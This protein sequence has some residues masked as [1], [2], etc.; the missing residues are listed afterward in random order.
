MDTTTVTHPALNKADQ[1]VQAAT[2][3]AQSWSQV[4]G[5]LADNPDIAAN[6]GSDQSTQRMHVF[7]GHKPD[8]VTVIADAARRAVAAGA[9]PVEHSHHTF[10]GVCLRFGRVEVYV[11]ARSEQVCQPV[12]VGMVPDVRH[13][14]SIALDE[15]TVPAGQAG[16]RPPA[17]GETR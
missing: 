1:A 2:S 16:H 10:G 4:A 12:T 8:P 17:Q 15:I 6:A 13:R 14:L 11:Y 5:F 9:E 7:V 3:L